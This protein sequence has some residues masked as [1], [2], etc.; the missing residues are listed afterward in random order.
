MQGPS[1]KDFAYFSCRWTSQRCICSSQGIKLTCNIIFNRVMSRGWLISKRMRTSGQCKVSLSGC[2]KEVFYLL[3][4]KRQ[5]ELDKRCAKVYSWLWL[6]DWSGDDLIYLVKWSMKFITF[7]HRLSYMV[8]AVS[9]SQLI[10]LDWV[11]YPCELGFDGC[12]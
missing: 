7:I 5:Y 12:T 8:L 10:G 4:E 11:L 1:W 6:Q 2:F 3:Y 9:V